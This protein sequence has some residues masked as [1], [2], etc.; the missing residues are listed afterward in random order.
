[1]ILSHGSCLAKSKFDKS[2]ELKNISDNTF[3]FSDH[4][5]LLNCHY[6]HGILWEKID[7]SRDRQNPRPNFD[8]PHSHCQCHWLPLFSPEAVVTFT[9][10]GSLQ[11]DIKLYELCQDLQKL[12]CLVV[13][14]SFPFVSCLGM[15][16]TMSKSSLENSRSRDVVVNNRQKLGH[17]LISKIAPALSR[18]QGTPA[19]HIF[20]AWLR[21]LPTKSTMFLMYYDDDEGNRVYTLKVR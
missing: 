9:V 11:S 7:F 14:V 21:K 19:F 3:T 20:Q 1:M 12:T 2:M 17:D 13:I 5:S 8:G 18:Q 4:M 6:V 15:C 16:G 10:S